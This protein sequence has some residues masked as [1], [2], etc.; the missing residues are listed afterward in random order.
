MCYY[1]A[2]QGFERYAGLERCEKTLYL[3]ADQAKL[4][5]SI[6][7]S[8]AKQRDACVMFALIAALGNSGDLSA[9]VPGGKLD[10][11]FKGQWRE[12]DPETFRNTLR[13]FSR[14]VKRPVVLH[15]TEAEKGTLVTTQRIDIEFP[16]YRGNPI[17]QVV[18]VPT[19]EGKRHLL[20]IGSYNAQPVPFEDLEIVTPPAATQVPQ[21][22]A[23]APVI[24]TEAVEQAQSVLAQAPAQPE[25]L[26]GNT[27]GEN[28]S[29][30]TR[31]S[32]EVPAKKRERTADID[33]M[34]PVEH[35]DEWFADWYT[36]ENPPFARYEGWWPP[37]A[38]MGLEWVGGWVAGNAPAEATTPSTWRSVADV[39]CAS[40]AYASIYG[41]HVEYLPM[42]IDL[43]GLHKV[44]LRSFCSAGAEVR[45]SHFVAGDT[46]RIGDVRYAVLPSRKRA[47]LLRLAR[48][49][50]ESPV[51][52]LF[53]GLGRSVGQ[54]IPLIPWGKVGCRAVDL[55]M[56]RSD[57]S[58]EPGVVP[59]NLTP[60]WRQKL[61]WII[62]RGAAPV[63]AQAA[64]SALMTFARAKD[65]GDGRLS[66]FET[67]PA[68]SRVLKATAGVQYGH[69]GGTALGRKTGTYFAWGDCYSCGKV[70]PGKRLPGRMCKHCEPTVSSRYCSEGWRVTRHG[71]VVYPGVVQTDSRHPPLK[72]SKETTATPLCFREPPSGARSCRSSRLTP[73]VGR[74]W[75]ESA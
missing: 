51:T 53:R 25:V 61:E 7:T 55:A 43:T 56:S 18:S 52:T 1:H 62:V 69:C 71:E 4:M 9:W 10:S 37:P 40:L 57:C 72:R 24:K 30:T 20:P 66:A 15:W 47:G 31:C 26:G 45:D 11:A 29:T 35:F 70:L 49:K 17:V 8:H 27:V 42:P 41:D 74:G 73:A 63:E 44:G 67:A 22:P 54:C 6:D 38:E 59:D 19:F 64:I 50:E 23:P 60:E 13:D 75:V 14:A 68:V 46:V 36:D 48:L 2:W 21:P 33:Y 32:P 3:T 28:G 5:S 34:V 65:W 16:R 12:Q 58:V 39:V